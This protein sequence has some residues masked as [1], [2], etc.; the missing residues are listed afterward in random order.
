MI[1]PA[2]TRA[3][4]LRRLRAAAGP[5]RALGVARLAL[6][7]SFARDEADPH[8]D[9]DLL[10]QFETGRKSFDRLLDLGDLLESR[11]ARRVELV[12]TEGLSPYLGPHIRAEA[13][14][15]P[16]GP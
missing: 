16:L 12:T 6:F 2:S 7:G 9:V 1:A 10:V 13:Q 14:D 15:V 5:I 11:L 3:E 8:S 4:V